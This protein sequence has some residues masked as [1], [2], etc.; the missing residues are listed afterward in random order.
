MKNIHIHIHIHINVTEPATQTNSLE[1][2]IK[3]MDAAFAD[4]HAA[5]APLKPMPSPAQDAAKVREHNRREINRAA[6]QM[7]AMEDLAKATFDETPLNPHCLGTA[8][9]LRETPDAL[10]DILSYLQ[11]EKAKRCAVPQSPNPQGAESSSPAASYTQPSQTP[12]A[13]RGKE[14]L[15]RM[16]LHEL[17]LARNANHPSG[18]AV[19]P[20]ESQ[21]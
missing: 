20:S 6:A 16:V 15:V 5:A 17:T 3:K 9:L 18:T 19:P 10:L 11:D 7:K 21:A 13:R 4:L 12:Q 8:A 1:P 2:L 14:R